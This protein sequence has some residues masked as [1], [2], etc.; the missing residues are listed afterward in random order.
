MK[1]KYILRMVMKLFQTREKFHFSLYFGLG[2]NLHDFLHLSQ[3]IH[4]CFL[5]VPFLARMAYWP[6]WDRLGPNKVRQWKLP[7][8]DRPLLSTASILKGQSVKTGL[9]TSERPLCELNQL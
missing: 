6:S 4:V 5:T 7:G 3:Q 8:R 9:Q 1:M 2:G